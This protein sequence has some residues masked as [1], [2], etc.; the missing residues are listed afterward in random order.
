[1][2]ARRASWAIFALYA[3]LATAWSW[4]M[5]RLRADTLVTLHFDLYPTVW[6]LER[7]PRVLPEL[8]HAESAWPDGESLA[9]VDSYVILVLAWVLR[10]VLGGA[11]VAALVGWLGPAVGAWAAERVAH[12]T[13]GIPR[14]ASLLAGLSFG[15]AGIAATAVLEGHVY[16]LLAPWLPLLLGDLWGASPEPPRAAWIRGARAGLWWAL[17]L[18][19]TAYFGILGAALIAVA[20]GRDALLARGAPVEGTVR[21]WAGLLAVALPAGLA[22]IALFARG[23]AWAGSGDDPTT[24]WRTGAVTLAG[25]L[26]WTPEADAYRHSNGAPLGFVVAGLVVL[27]PAVLSGRRGWRTLAAVAVGAVVLALGRELRVHLEDDGTWWPGAWVASLPGARWFRFPV[28]LT[29]LW[30]LCGGIV[31]A[32]T[33]A[34]LTE[35]E[36]GRGYRWTTL[37]TLLLALGDIAVGQATPLRLRARAAPLPSAYLA[38][39]EGRPVLD[40]FAPPADG[41]NVEAEMWVRALGC[42]YQSM[43]GRP[44]LEVCIGTDVQSPREREAEALLDGLLA[45]TPDPDA[46]DARVRTLGVGAVALHADGFRPSEHAA[47]ESG[48]TALWG[49]PVTA[50]DGGRVMLWMVPAR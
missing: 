15:F 22:Y 31:A 6:L 29:W 12:R 19:T 1:M 13:F 43:H 7:A 24:V 18:W 8:W 35:G 48:M 20:A 5:A 9:R 41:A 38:A 17:C 23:G 42:Y 28:R 25:L 40:V 26:G 10:P 44:T 2:S 30:A 39:P 37:V 33:L 36:D 16:H 34:R 21:R 14:P 50:E 45:R 47:L 49:A 4:P 3:A 11:Q 46:V 32:R 27:A